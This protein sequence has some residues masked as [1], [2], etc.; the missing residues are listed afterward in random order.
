[1]SGLRE[2]EDKLSAQGKDF[3]RNLLLGSVFSE[4]T[5]R[6]MG[7]DSVLKNKALNGIRA[8]IE[9][10]K[11]GDY[12]LGEEIDKAMQLLYEARQAGGGVDALLRTTAM[13]GEN[14]ADRYD[15]IS[16]AIALA[17]EGK[18][19]DFRELM[20]AYNRNAVHYADATQMEMFGEKPTK[21]E[22]VNEFLKFRNWK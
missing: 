8:V 11:L 15:P 12:A 4:N 17:L 10:M 13:F 22:F 7:N 9:N 14:A 18:A 19:E 6:M 2:G 3:V 21:E 1:M 20:L 5:I 16:Q